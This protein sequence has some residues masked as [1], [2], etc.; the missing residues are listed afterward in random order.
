MAR[1]KD[2]KIESGSQFKAIFKKDLKTLFS[3]IVFLSGP[4]GMVMVI[5]VMGFVQA[6]RA[7]EESGVDPASPEFLLFAFL[8]SLAV[9]LFI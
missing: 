6:S 1:P 7:M 4:L 3:N 5:L 8:I 2:I 9:G